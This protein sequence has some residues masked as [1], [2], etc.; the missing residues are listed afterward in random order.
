MRRSSARQR[1]VAL[2]MAIAVLGVVAASCVA[3][4]LAVGNDF[5]RVRLDRERLQQEQYELAS[6][7]I[8]HAQLKAGRP[9]DGALPLPADAG[10]ATIAWTTD[11]VGIRTCLI[12]IAGREARY[13][14]RQEGT[15]WTLAKPG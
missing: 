9:T 2:V 7:A 1:G 3:L 5:T 15:A 8:A 6:I 11:P 4:L 13:A 14:F 10:E 12:T